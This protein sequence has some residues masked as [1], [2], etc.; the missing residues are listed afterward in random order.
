MVVSRDDSP[1]SG[2]S[3]SK[4]PISKEAGET[5]MTNLA[6]SVVLQASVLAAPGQPYDQA[7]QNSVASGRPLVVLLGA[8]WC[9]ACVKMKNSILP[10][11]EKAGGLRCVELTYVDVDRQPRLAQGLSR[12]ASIPQLIRFERK[13]DQ[14]VSQLLTGAHSTR[15]VSEFLACPQPERGPPSWSARLS[16]WSQSVLGG[17]R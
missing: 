14:W 15:K 7:Y 9:P 13:G 16:A 3:G 1:A 11:V 4:S 5:T 10:E 8:D 2:P 12:G 6:L 17:S